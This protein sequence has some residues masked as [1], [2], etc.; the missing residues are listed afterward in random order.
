MLAVLGVSLL[1]LGVTATRVV[2]EGRSDDRRT[3]DVLVV[4]GAAQ[5][6]GTP[7]P[8]LTARL[9]HA[10]TLFEDGVAPRIVTTGGSLEGDRFTE[11]E[12]G[13]AWLA[14][15]GV[16]QDAV[17]VVGEG[18]D[19]LSTLQAVAPVLD[20]AG[21]QSAVVVT[22]PPHLLRSVSM[23]GNQG[24]DAVGSPVPNSPDSGH[25]WAQTRYVARESA[26]YLY[27]QLQRLVP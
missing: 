22:D 15:R 11:A 14:E 20:D 10:L 12:S 24:I 3:S 9:E 26:G 1:M 7:G 4:L 17:V 2:L 6:D 18:D 5:F 21:W 8:H 16:P 13:A 19:T 27:Y 23:L 25:L